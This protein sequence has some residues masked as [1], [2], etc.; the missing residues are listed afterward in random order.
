MKSK[1]NETNGVFDTIELNENSPIESS[2]GRLSGF[3]SY[4]YNLISGFRRSFTRNCDSSFLST[5][6]DKSYYSIL[7][8]SMKVIATFLLSFGIISLVL[9]YFMHMNFRQ[10][11]LDTE[12]LNT[13][14]IIIIS[15]LFF[16]SKKKFGE[17]ISTSKFTSNLSIAYNQAEVFAQD[18]KTAKHQEGYSTAFFLGVLAGICSV[19]FPSSAIVVF[20]LAAVYCVFI[21][22]RP[23]CGLMLTIFA[24]PFFN[25]TSIIFLSLITFAALLYRYLRGKRH[26]DF[27][28]VQSIL[29]VILAYILIRGFCTNAKFVNYGQV[30][31]FVSFF[32]VFITVISLIRSTS[33]L[34]RS[35]K[36]IMNTARIY[37]IILVCYIVLCAIFSMQTTNN[38]LSNFAFTGLLSALT[39]Q[40][41]IMS[42]I[43]I[44]FPLNFSM[45]FGDRKSPERIKNTT[46]FILLL[47][48]ATYFASYEFVLTILVFGIIN[49]IFV[50]P[51]YFFLLIPCPL[52][53][54]GVIKLRSFIPAKFILNTI[55]TPDNNI[56]GIKSLVAD[57]PL[58]GVGIGTDA[59][60]TLLGEETNINSS[61]VNLLSH[62][63]TVGMILLLAFVFVV[64]FKSVKS[65]YMSSITTESAK[66]IAI[67]LVSSSLSAFST[68][69]FC[70]GLSDYRIVFLFSVVTA[71]AYCSGRCYDADYIDNTSVREYHQF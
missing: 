31:N 52:V 40:R 3:K 47:V 48:L 51:K 10:F 34:R 29:L 28:L 18:S 55:S 20:I 57:N 68:F 27:G 38:Y 39:N 64:L 42:F 22:G 45:L 43:A 14:A 35:I 46:F 65:I 63:G 36:I 8:C 4:I 54:Y 62:L 9:S 61:F 41:F 37:T 25:E 5:G 7:A 33:M 16:T 15:L 70:D 66:T 71:L 53:A 32:L 6:L 67:G 19:L 23:E 30:L 21:F 26:I 24:V 50:K 49:I 2:G 69:F 17:M 60:K 11:L 44:F 1:T 12:T 58:F 13:V 56:E 59:F